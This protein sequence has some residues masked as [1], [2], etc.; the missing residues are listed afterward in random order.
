MSQQFTP[1]N[2]APFTQDW[3]K[4][5]ADRTISQCGTAFFCPSRPGALV[6]IFCGY[7]APCFHPQGRPGACAEQQNTFA[8]FGPPRTL[9]HTEREIGTKTLPDKL[10]KLGISLVDDARSYLCLECKGLLELRSSHTANS[11]GGKHPT[12][13][14]ALLARYPLGSRKGFLPGA[15][16]LKRNK[17]TTYP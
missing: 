9:A 1:L 13:K 3:R 5:R 15:G 10:K 16:S 12:R 14:I 2:A 4:V 11:A 17:H 6:R 8:G 7:G